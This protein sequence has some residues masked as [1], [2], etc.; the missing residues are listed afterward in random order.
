VNE[1][2]YLEKSGSEKELFRKRME[3]DSLRKKIDKK[4]S[5]ADVK[6]YKAIEENIPSGFRFFLQQA[7]Q[8]PF[9]ILF[10]TCL[11]LAFLIYL[12]D[13]RRRYLRRIALSLRI[14]KREGY[15]DIYDYNLSLPFWVFPVPRDS[16]NGVRKEDMI[17][18]GNTRTRRQEYKMYILFLLAVLVFIQYRLFY[19]SLITNSGIY[20]WV[21]PVQSVLLGVT[22]ALVVLWLLPSTLRDRYNHEAKDH[23]YARR[24]F[25]TASSLT[26]AGLGL[27]TTS[28]RISNFLINNIL[29]PRYK[30]KNKTTKP[31]RLW[32]KTERQARIEIDKGNYEQAANLLFDAINRK[33]NS[34]TLIHYTRLFDLLIRLSRKHEQVKKNMLIPTIR[35]AE[36]SGN[37]KL[38][39]K[40]AAWQKKLNNKTGDS[41]AGH[42]KNN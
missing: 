35:I 38:T 3:Y 6:I 28:T 32:N 14:H 17:L 24:N 40:A 34:S 21:L 15:N 36:A 16:A 23:H 29:K 12:Y 30:A 39:A 20:W 33:K 26:L 42:A 10:I 25:I 13:L 9:G 1:E 8:R 22:V 5:E 19:I 27:G 41:N 37:K 18:I 31:E 7:V 2:A 11:A 4:Q